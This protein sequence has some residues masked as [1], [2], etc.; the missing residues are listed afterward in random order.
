[1]LASAIRE[2]PSLTG[3][4]LV[5]IVERSPARSS[6]TSMTSAEA[7]ASRVQ[8]VMAK[9]LEQCCVGRPRGS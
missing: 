6:I 3:S 4:W 1:M 8:L 5:T 2:C 9:R 7:W